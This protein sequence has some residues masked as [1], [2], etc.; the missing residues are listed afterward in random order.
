MEMPRSSR[1]NEVLDFDKNDT[2]E[3]IG[4][5]SSKKLVENKQF[6]DNLYKILSK[7]SQSH[8]LQQGI[9]EIRKLM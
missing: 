5:G 6:T 9:E 8:T 3:I 4:R 2:L 1:N 7:F